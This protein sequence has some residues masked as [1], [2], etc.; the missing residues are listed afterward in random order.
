L[1]IIDLYCVVLNRVDTWG[2]KKMNEEKIRQQVILEY[3]SGEVSLRT[4]AAKYNYNHNL[5]YRWI[6]A[7]Q[8]LKKKEKRLNP[9]AVVTALP[10]LKPMSTDVGW[11]QEQ[12]RLSRIE[13]LLLQATID[14]SDEKFGT[15][16]KKKAGTR[17]S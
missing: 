7:H 14:I 10:E 6:M 3:L 17:Q 5:I 1:F 9:G 16:M 12:L 13:I 11:L 4:L 2:T 8:R 15:N